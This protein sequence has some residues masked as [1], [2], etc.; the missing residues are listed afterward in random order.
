MCFKGQLGMLGL[1]RRFITPQVCSRLLRL[2]IFFAV[3][4]CAI[5]TATAA[6]LTIDLFLHPAVSDGRA[7]FQRTDFQHS[8]SSNS[9]LTFRSGSGSR[10]GG[11][12][13]NA[14][15]VFRDA[16]RQHEFRFVDHKK[17]K[18]KALFLRDIP[19]ATGTSTI[20]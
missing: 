10:M 13:S 20:R 15:A 2:Q 5:S 11:F 3:L 8:G 7:I 18:T 19:T 9:F 14:A 12:N 16:A 4:G 1:A 6:P 17:N